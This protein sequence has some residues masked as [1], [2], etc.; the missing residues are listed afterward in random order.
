MNKK[1]VQV[2][3]D[4]KEEEDKN[5]NP[6]VSDL[7]TEDPNNR[8]DEKQNIL[9]ESPDKDQK[10]MSSILAT[11]WLGAQNGMLYVHSSVTNWNQ[12]LHSVKLDNGILSIV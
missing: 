1:R 3:E 11:M 8:I 7:M 4:N 5:K 12:C 10:A 9:E 2:Q 6:N